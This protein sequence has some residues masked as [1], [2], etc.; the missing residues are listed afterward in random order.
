MTTRVGS[1]PVCESMTLTRRMRPIEPQ[2]GT[3]VT[4]VFLCGSLRI[5]AFSVLKDHFNTG[6]AEIR[7][8]SQ[9]N[10]KFGYDIRRCVF[11][12][13]PEFRSSERQVTKCASFS[14]S[15]FCCC[16]PVWLPH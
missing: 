3:K 16:V 15:F 6:A 4:N 12:N 11:T 7:K 5:F 2:K 8:G 10:L 13:G 14:P 9:R 1:P